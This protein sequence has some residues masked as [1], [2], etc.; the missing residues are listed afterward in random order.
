MIYD[1]DLKIKSQKNISSKQLINNLLKSEQKMRSTLFAIAA[2]ILSMSTEAIKVEQM[3]LKESKDKCKG[4]L[5]GALE[6]I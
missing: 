2:A 4:Y 5:K 1:S 6:N 3:E